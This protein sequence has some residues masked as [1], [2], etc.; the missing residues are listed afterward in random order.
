ML[1]MFIQT[2]SVKANENIFMV[3]GLAKVSFF[4]FFLR[5]EI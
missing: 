1:R 4:L 2:F 3:P 5:G